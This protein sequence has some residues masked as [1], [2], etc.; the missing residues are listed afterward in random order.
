[1]IRCF[2]I[3]DAHNTTLSYRHKNAFCRIFADFQFFFP[4]QKIYGICLHPKYS[5]WFALRGVF[6]FKDIHVPE[7]ERRLPVDILPDNEGRIR[8]LEQ[9]NFHWQDWTYRDVAPAQEKYSEEQ[10]LY[11]GTLPKE[12]PQIL[13][14]LISSESHIEIP[15]SSIQD[16][17]H[18]GSLKS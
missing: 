12:R 13:H 3:S 17:G 8:L 10:K 4:F 9:F 7:L 16:V 11:F 2:R 6:I 18:V 15:S 5:G 14:K 1:M